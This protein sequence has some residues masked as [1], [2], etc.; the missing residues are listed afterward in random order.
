MK[1]AREELDIITAYQ[2]LGTYRAAA[3]HCG[4]THKTVA[5]VIAKQEAGRSGFTRAPRPSNYDNVRDVVVARVEKTHGRITAKRLLPEAGAAGYEGSARNFRRLV[6]QVKKD[7]RTAHARGRR[8]AVWAP[9]EHLV[10]DWGVLAGLHVFCAVLAHSRFRFVRFAD[11]ER[12][13]TTLGFLA[14]CF[15][16][17]GGVPRVV[18]ADRM[19][20]LKGG[21][22][23]DLVVPTADYVRFASHYRF[24]PD[25]CQGADP[26]SKGIVENL[27]G[28]AKTDLMV[29][30]G[31]LDGVVAGRTADGEPVDLAWVNTMAK[32]WCSEVNAVEHSDICAIPDQRLDL[33]RDLLTPLPSLRPS[34]GRRTTRKVDS[35]SCVRFS[36]A[37][38]SVPVKWRGT[39]VELL[40][41]EGRLDV[42]VPGTG[43]LVATHQ[44]L[45]AGETS[46]LD[47]HYGGA[48]PSVPPRALRPKTPAERDFLALGPV[49]EAWLRGAAAAGNTRL[50]P[51][52]AALVDLVAA[53][54][55]DHVLAAL[56]RA[57]NFAR[58]QA[59]DIASILA[60][61]TG[62]AEII[63]AGDALVLPL[64][65]TK[66]RDLDAYSITALAGGDR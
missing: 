24:R 48:R 20:C 26:A 19:G 62:V 37:R 63:P 21:V 30:L 51:E 55:K 16:L 41:T 46:I 7:Y 18:L 61:G 38:Y 50:G 42:R 47:E 52:L 34:I 3:E 29:G 13:E 4:T 54:G 27:V 40:V 59:A 36:S 32:L 12:S 23:A 66:T 56:T 28:Y 5:R 45:A 11:N 22:T 58:W 17:L 2:E 14:E 25:F 65:V 6:A 15:E 39:T 8:P 33:E 9:G 57:V 35:L 1:S 49:A 43:E 44:V 53:H 60:A 31:L 64:P 10:I